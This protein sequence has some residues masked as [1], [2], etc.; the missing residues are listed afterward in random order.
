MLRKTGY[1]L[2]QKRRQKSSPTCGGTQS[3]SYIARL[4]RLTPGGLGL[5][6]PEGSTGLCEG[7]RRRPEKVTECPGW[8]RHLEKFLVFPN[9]QFFLT[10]RYV[11]SSQTPISSPYLSLSSVSLQMGL[12]DVSSVG[13]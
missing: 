7:G 11:R 13:L 3:T 5:Q 2:I 8:S 6:P 12:S 1:S 10:G 9:V 4:P